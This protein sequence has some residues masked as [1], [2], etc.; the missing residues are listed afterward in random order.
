MKTLFIIACAAVILAGIGKVKRSAEG[1]ENADV[2]LNA[3]TLTFVGGVGIL[4]LL[5]LAALSL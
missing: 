2:I 3:H 1:I 5:G 4:I